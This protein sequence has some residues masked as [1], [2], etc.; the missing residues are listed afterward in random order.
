VKIGITGA[1]G[2]LAPLLLRH[3]HDQGAEVSQYSRVGKDGVLPLTELFQ[4]PPKDMLIHCAWS[5]VPLTAEADPGAFDRE[6]LPL[7]KKIVQATAGHGTRIVFPSSGAIYGNTGDSPASEDDLPNPLGAYAKAKIAA[8]NFLLENA[9]SRVFILRATNL[10]GEAGDPQKPQGIL[11]R[12]VD[13]AL[14]GSVVELWGD[15][16]A[17]KD[18]VHYSDFFTGLEAALNSGSPGLWNV[19]CGISH[20]LLEIIQIVED[21]TQKKINLVHRP[22]FDWDVTHSQICVDKLRATGWQ[23]KKSLSGAIEDFLHRTK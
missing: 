10:L 5:T 7:L 2:R 16:S 4:N 20:S 11:P 9:A 23:P 18:Y 12:F 14:K 17:T 21:L 15:G 22:H 8:E 13:S 19:G 3:F 6:D 1:R